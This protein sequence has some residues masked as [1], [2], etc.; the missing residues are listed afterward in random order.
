MYYASH[1]RPWLDDRKGLLLLL[2]SRLELLLQVE[3]PVSGIALIREGYRDPV[4]VFIKDEP[5]KAEKMETGRLR[6]ISSVSLLD[7]LVE[8]VL[9]SWQNK[10]EIALWDYLPF[11]PGMGHH[12]EGKK[13]LYDYFC[14]CQAEGPIASTDISG[15]DWSVRQWLMDA[16]R[17]YRLR[18]GC[19]TGGWARL[20]RSYFHC[21]ARCVFVS[22]DGTC[23]EQDGGI[24]K[25]GSYIT[26]S[27]NSHMRY[28]LASIVQR[29]LG[30]P[31][32]RYNGCQMGDDALERYVDGMLDE[33]KKFGFQA[34]GVAEQKLGEF[35]FCSHSYK[36][37]KGEPTSWKKTIFRH[38]AKDPNSSEYPVWREQL[39]YELRHSPIL[40]E[41]LPRVDQ[42]MERKTR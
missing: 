14:K 41:V 8:R 36:S 29:R 3:L 22:G 28:I 26:S 4:Y 20:V 16:E 32:T 13:K 21:N 17:D 23:F 25:S 24:Q 37:W 39:E 10:K 34:R 12:D 9:F 38:L 40:G 30:V 18:T 31:R 11:K 42:Y 27:G 6:L 5:H 35:E 15:W 33:Y 7:S 19:N 1:K 2:F